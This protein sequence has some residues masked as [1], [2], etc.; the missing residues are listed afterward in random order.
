[1]RA[2]A[3]FILE[4]FIKKIAFNFPRDISFFVI[5]QETFVHLLPNM[6]WCTLWFKKLCPKNKDIKF[7]HTW[8]KKVSTH[9]LVLTSHSNP[10]SVF[11]KKEKYHHIQ[12]FLA[13]KKYFHKRVRFN[14]VFLVF[15]RTTKKF[16]LKSGIMLLF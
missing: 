10:T 15:C 16:C 2:T 12:W 8:T 11:E 6:V 5:F 9:F 14:I 3:V 13:L 4:C 1:M 7:T